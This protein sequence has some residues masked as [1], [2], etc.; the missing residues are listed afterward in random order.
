[1]DQFL[2]SVAHKELRNQHTR[3]NSK[4]LKY[5]LCQEIPRRISKVYTL[6]NSFKIFLIHLSLQ[7]HSHYNIPISFTSLLKYR[8]MHLCV[9]SHSVI[10]VKKCWL[11]CNVRK[12]IFPLNYLPNKHCFS[13]FPV[14]S[15][16]DLKLTSITQILKKI[17]YINLYFQGLEWFCSY[18]HSHH[19]PEDQTKISLTVL[20]G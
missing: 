13:F 16:S 19:P 7:N 18:G 20:S 17:F 14:F 5:L 3:N 4:L 15:L 10:T 1:M 8:Y 11:L 2:F 12:I 6:Q 9:F